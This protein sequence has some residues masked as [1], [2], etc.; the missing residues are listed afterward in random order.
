MLRGDNAAL[1][2]RVA[3]LEQRLRQSSRNSSL[4]PSQDP[5]SSPPRPRKPG[6]GRQRGGQPGHEGRHRP[7]LPLEQVDRVVEHWP[8]RCARCARE[9]GEAEHVDAAEPQRRQLWEL[10]PLT[11][12]V[13]E[14]RLHRARCPGCGGETRAELPPELPRSAFGPRL[15]AAVATLSVRNR[16]SRRDVGELS[17]ELFGC[18]LSLGAVDAICQ[19]ASAALAR[20]HRELH[21]AV[22]H[23]PVVNADETGWK[24]AGER[25][26]LWAGLTPTLAAFL[27]TGSRGQDSARALLGE[28][29]QGTCVSDRFSGYKH[30]A[31]ER[32]A[33][34]WSHLVRDFRKL[35]ERSG[36]A[37]E[38]GQ[39]ALALCERLFAAWHTYR[40]EGRGR[41]W[42]GEQVAPLKGELRALLE[43]GQTEGDRETKTLCRSLLT[44]WPA[45]WSFVDNDGVEPTNNAAERGLRGAVIYRKTS[46]GNQSD[47]GA[48][49]VERMLSIAVTCRLQRR[50]LFAYLTQALEATARGQPTPSLVPP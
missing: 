26:W 41:A 34:C 17:E 19:R 37:S 29:F 2:E 49:F 45:L 28:D 50:S 21:E 36:T 38:I 40:R 16:V 10:P 18:P 1:K 32:R 24:Q 35:E 14:H 23:S 46:F 25:R 22:K 30:L 7:L 6:S 5:P 39:A 20:P 8:A 9:L 42:L 4:P 31:L 11:V 47:A 33:L 48:R 3:E 15:E 27:I 43:R 44:L 12:A 13:T